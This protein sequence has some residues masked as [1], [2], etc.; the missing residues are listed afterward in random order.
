MIEAIRFLWLAWG[1]YRD[2]KKR[3][4]VTYSAILCRDVPQVAIF[5]GLGREAWRISQKAIEEY[6]G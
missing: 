1:A 5:V 4:G 6:R 2:A 3:G